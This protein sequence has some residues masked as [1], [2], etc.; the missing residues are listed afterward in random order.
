MYL[1]IIIISNAP[2]PAPTVRDSSIAGEAASQIEWAPLRCPGHDPV[3]Y[4]LQVRM[5]TRDIEFTT[6][7]IPGNFAEI[8]W[9]F[10][11]K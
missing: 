9:N 1:N 10:L 3:S 8:P 6:V 7:S 11:E 5:A 4:V 2:P